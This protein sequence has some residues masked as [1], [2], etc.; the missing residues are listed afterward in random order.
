M[1][2][3]LYLV[4]G[5]LLGAVAI[6]GAVSALTERRAPV[7]ALFMLLV[8]GGLVAY[9]YQLSPGGLTLDEVPRALT[10]VIGRIIN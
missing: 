7:A 1:N 9:A 2:A 10:R 4:I 6:P 5:C 8:G 3:D